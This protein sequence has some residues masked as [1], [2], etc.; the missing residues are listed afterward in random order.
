MH[1]RRLIHVPHH[2]NKGPPASW[3]LVLPPDK[4]KNN[5]LFMLTSTKKMK[6]KPLSQQ[7]LTSSQCTTPTTVCCQSRFFY[8]RKI[9]SVSQPYSRNKIFTKL[10]YISRN[11]F[12]DYIQAGSIWREFT[13]FCKTDIT[14][15]TALKLTDTGLLLIKI[16]LYY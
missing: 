14:Q 5:L 3:C 4:T 1:M 7:H 2:Y 6:H 15:V 13:G 9:L 8:L 10:F 11:D 16:K 12:L